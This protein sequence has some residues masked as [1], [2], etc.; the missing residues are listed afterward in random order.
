ML[1]SS[2]F[3]FHEALVVKSMF[4]KFDKDNEPE[5]SEKFTIQPFGVINLE[6]NQFQLT[7]SVQF[8]DNKEGIAIEV[9]IM[10]LFSFE[11]EVEEIKQF[12]CL[13][14]PAILFPYLR[15]YIT[16]LTS[17]S[18]FNSIILPTMNLSGLKGVLEENLVFK[19]N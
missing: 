4:I 18:G 9:D 16:A 12:L 13:N 17:L 11:G 6:A 7:L 10:G 15:S 2:G 19:P 1:K 3:R 14:A 8:E 5:P